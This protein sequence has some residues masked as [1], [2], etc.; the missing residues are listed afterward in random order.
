MFKPNLEQPVD[1][2]SISNSSE[3][4]NKT[5]SNFMGFAARVQNAED[6]TTFEDIEFERLYIVVTTPILTI[7]G[8]NNHENLSTQ[9]AGEKNSKGQRH[10]V[11]KQIYDN[12]SYYVGQWVE[13]LKEGEGEMNYANGTRYIGGWAAGKAN[14]AGQFLSSEGYRYCGNF[15][16]GEAHCASGSLEW[17]SCR[18]EALFEN[19]KI[20]GKGK[21]EIGG[22]KY[23]GMF[24]NNFLEGP[25]TC[26]FENGDYYEGDFHLNKIEGE[27]S[28]T[29]ASDV[30][31]YKGHF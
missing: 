10:G 1:D 16:N 8:D 25:G 4:S 6:Q 31:N 14:G 13:G 28:I 9:Y 11:G 22:N 17:Y 19:G 30:S 15:R 20:N 26:Q 29:Y 3:D 2:D 23:T 27:G 18:V 21:I 24:K 12:G 5:E 7:E